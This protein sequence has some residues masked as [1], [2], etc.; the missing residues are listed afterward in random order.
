ME[1]CTSW[2]GL[3]SQYSLYNFILR[4]VKNLSENTMYDSGKEKRRRGQTS[5]E[6][7]SCCHGHPKAPTVETVN[8]GNDYH[9]TN[10]LAFSIPEQSWTRR[11]TYFLKEAAATA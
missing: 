11:L 1:M 6:G 10:S 2:P 8:F 5:K 7:V 9:H 3:K 4:I